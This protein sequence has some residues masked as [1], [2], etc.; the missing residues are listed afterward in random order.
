MTEPLGR[1]T[2]T[3]MSGAEQFRSDG[4]DLGFDL[5]GFWRW[6]T[7]DL[8][9]NTTRGR[10]AEYVVA[11]ALGIACDGVCD[12]WAAF[13]LLTPSG[14][15][16]E[17]KSAAYIQ[18]WRQQRTSRVSFVV[19]K[20]RAWDAETGMLAGEPR[21]HADVYVFA[22]LAHADK[23]TIDPLEVGQWRFYVLPTTALDARKRSQHSITLTSLERLAGAPVGYAGLQEAVERAVAR[24][25]ND[26]QNVSEEGRS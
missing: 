2:P 1:R 19:P 9:S 26:Q 14:L 12:E 3:R 5:L 7:S 15:R 23:A 8:V 6:I 21:R 17:V 4:K 22:L 10:L 11:H 24:K 18:S 25:S 16:V 13:D 20:R